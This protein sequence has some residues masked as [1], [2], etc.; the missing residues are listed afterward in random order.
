LAGLR[1]RRFSVGSCHPLQ[2]FNSASG[3]VRLARKSFFCV[4]GDPSAVRAARNLVRRIGARHF[5]IKPGAKGLYHAAAVLASGGVTALVSI[6]L[7]AL[8]ACSLGELQSRSVLLPLVEGTIRNVRSAGPARAL[9]GPVRRGDAGT[10]RLNLDALGKIDPDW[11][12]LYRLLSRRAL[13]LARHARTPGERLESV[14][15]LVA[16]PISNR[17]R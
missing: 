16:A 10:I 9:T 8:R 14:S 11:R 17:K 7:E 13:V 5:E 1:R 6:S 15:Q 12:E 3:G 2:T 4:E